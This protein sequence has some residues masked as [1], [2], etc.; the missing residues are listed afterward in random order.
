MHVHLSGPPMLKIDSSQV[1]HY[2]EHHVLLVPYTA[3]KDVEDYFPYHNIGLIM[4]FQLMTS[5]AFSLSIPSLYKFITTPT[6]QPEEL[7]CTDLEVC[8]CN[9]FHW[10]DLLGSIL[11]NFILCIYTWGWYFHS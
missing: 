3:K 1:P 10:Q 2:I 4:L 11:A 9:S 6:S 8:V 7:R 5:A